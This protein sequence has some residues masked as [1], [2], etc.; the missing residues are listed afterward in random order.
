MTLYS[1]VLKQVH[2]CTEDCKHFEPVLETKS[3][4]RTTT[5][6]FIDKTEEDNWDYSLEYYGSTS[7][8]L[9]GKIQKPRKLVSAPKKLVKCHKVNYCHWKLAIIE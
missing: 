7:G 5:D 2:F 8:G 1:E 3:K 9:D 4:E 6:K